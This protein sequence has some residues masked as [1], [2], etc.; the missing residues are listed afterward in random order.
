MCQYSGG[1]AHGGRGGG[2]GGGGGEGEKRWR[3]AEEDVDDNGILVFCI[4]IHSI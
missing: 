3:G 1:L 2:G 4:S